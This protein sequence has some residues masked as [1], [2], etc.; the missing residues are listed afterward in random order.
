MKV[1]IVGSSDIERWEVIKIFTD[2]KRAEKFRNECDYWYD[3]SY[4]KGKQ[5]KEKNSSE[6]PSL[7]EIINTE[8]IFT[9]KEI[10]Q[11]KKLD[12]NII[13]Y[14]FCDPRMNSYFISEYPV[15]T[16][17]HKPS[18]EATHILPRRKFTR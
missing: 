6:I 16:S 4:K 15:D 10:K 9:K 2:K 18:L 14:M 12:E 8:I 5:Y 7:D 1:Y 17:Q 11:I 13:D 3:F